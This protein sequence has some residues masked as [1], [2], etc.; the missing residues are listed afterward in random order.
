MSEPL[1]IPRFLFR[2]AASCRYG[3]PLWT[4]KGAPL[5]EAYRLP[6]LAELDE[7]G[8]APDFRAAWSE[9]GL[10]FRVEVRGKKHPAWCRASQPA[11]SDGLQLWIDTRNVQNVHRATRFCHRLFFLPAG[12]GR[13]FARPVAGVLPIH[14]ARS[15]HAP[16][17][18]DQL[19]VVAQ[20]TDDGYILHAHVAAEAL[21][22]FDP[23]D[24]PALGFTYA[25]I[26]HEHGEWTFGPGSPMPYQEDPSFWATLDLVQS[27][28][29]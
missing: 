13:G 9:K 17:D 22:G 25:V 6:N 3:D 16:I 7:R 28:K 14:R 8:A 12:D 2:F 23:V 21:T 15:P 20:T 26:D 11:E 24:H 27:A 29:K 1:I 4:D 5:G 10:A 18:A 19:A